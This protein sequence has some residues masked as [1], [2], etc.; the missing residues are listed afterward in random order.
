[1]SHGH[2]H[3]KAAEGP[4]T[5]YLYKILVVRYLLKSS[6]P[7]FHLYTIIFNESS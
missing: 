2:G 5:E 3:G 7:P 4:A 6:S 1:M